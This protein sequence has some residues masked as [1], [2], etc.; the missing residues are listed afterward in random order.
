[1]HTGRLLEDCAQRLGDSNTFV[2]HIGGDDF[3]LVTTPDREGPVCKYIVKAFDESIPEFYDEQA[4]E[5]GRVE[6]KDRN[7]DVESFPLMSITIAVVN[8]RGKTFKST[9]VIA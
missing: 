2:G 4:R 6:F 8:N 7:G 1:M 3:V 9:R 5:Q